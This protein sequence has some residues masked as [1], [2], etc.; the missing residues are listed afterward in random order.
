M[1]PP[2]ASGTFA[3]AWAAYLRQLAARPLRTKMATSAALFAV[4]DCV[5]QFGIE[6][7]RPIRFARMAFYGGTVFAPLA[8]TWLGLVD[9]VRLASPAK[10]LAA[11]VALDQAAWGPFIVF[12]FWTTNGFL[13]GKTPSEVRRK[14]E[15]A[16]LPSWS[17]AVCVFAPTQI[18]NFTWV[19]LQHRLLFVQS[20]GLGWNIYLSY[21]NN[22]NNRRLA[23]AAAEVAAA[24]VG[25]NAGAG[26]D[27]ITA[28]EARQRLEAAERRKREI[29]DEEGGG[30]TGV[31]TR[32][33]CARRADTAITPRVRATSGERQDEWVRASREHSPD[34]IR[35]LDL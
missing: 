14:V 15:H 33:G 7:R 17:K 10:T 29:K 1:A 21:V 32:M 35:H 18:I 12:V 34:T 31:G 23:A 3:R 2:A 28:R 26:A 22:I 30:A 13:E 27:N 19:P 4:G 11:R 8:H 24:D 20:V 5:A 25:F 9:R 6:G 16:F